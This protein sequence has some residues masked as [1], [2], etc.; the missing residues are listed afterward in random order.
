MQEK[1]DKYVFESGES[2]GEAIPSHVGLA[3]FLGV[4][5]S[6]IYEWAKHHEAFSDTL[7][8]ISNCQEQKAVNHGIVGTFNP[9][10]TKLV[11]ANHGYSDKQE[12][13][14]TSPDGSMTPPSKIVLVS[15]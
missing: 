14:H 1:A 5:K 9:T 3:M 8:V 7:E 13:A 10:I 12:L 15:E 11:L 4:T 2:L 6:T